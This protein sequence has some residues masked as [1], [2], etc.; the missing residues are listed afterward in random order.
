MSDEHVREASFTFTASGSGMQLDVVTDHEQARAAED[1]Q[2]VHDV[3]TLE[4][5]YCS[6]TGML[7]GMCARQRQQ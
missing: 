1:T 6:E 5:G 7:P 2:G 4:H 3:D